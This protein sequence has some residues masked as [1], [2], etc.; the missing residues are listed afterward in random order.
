MKKGEGKEIYCAFRESF[1]RNN[2]N[3][4]N[5]LIRCAKCGKTLKITDQVCPNCGAPFYGNN[6]TVELK[7]E[8]THESLPKEVVYKEQFDSIYQLS[9]EEMLEEFIRRKMMKAK[10]DPIGKKLPKEIVQGKKFTYLLFSISLFTFV[11]L[12][13]FHLSLFVYVFGSF[14]FLFFFMEGKFDWM[15]YF[16]EQIQLRPGENVSFMMMDIK[17]TCVLDS[18]WKYLLIGILLSIVLPLLLFAKPR[19]F[20]ERVDQ[21]YAVRFYTI[22][23]VNATKI[24][25]PESYRE[26]PVVELK[27]G[28]F[29]NMYFLKEVSL[30]DTILRIGHYAFKN[31]SSLEKIA[32]PDSVTQ[33]GSSAFDECV[34]L[35]TVS[36]SK[37]SSLETIGP[38]AFSSCYRL[39]TIELPEDVEV[40]AA[41][42]YKSPTK[43]QFYRFSSFPKT[44]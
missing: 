29:S 27:D 2:P 17:K 39:D 8:G 25:I 42:F 1:L 11:S 4:R 10:I 26:K 33:I 24:T 13:F 15:D 36:I 9:E 44:K 23:L 3:E 18:S 30:P 6:V 5:L 19:I 22:G 34:H 40:D 14:F 21:G 28:V 41:A 12:F 20:Y 7:Q 38:L 31:D 43:I 37:D 35:K 32:L 16:K